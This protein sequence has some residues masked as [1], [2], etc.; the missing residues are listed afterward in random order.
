[1]LRHV[2]RFPSRE[3]TRSE[4]MLVHTGE[5]IRNYFAQPT[6]FQSKNPIR[7]PSPPPSS[8]ESITNTII[9]ESMDT[10][11]TPIA[12]SLD[13]SSRVTSEPD[14]MSPEETFKKVSFAD[15]PEKMEFEQDFPALEN[16][17]IFHDKCLTSPRQR[18]ASG[19]DMDLMMALSNKKE[20]QI[21]HKPS[22][23]PETLT[24]LM[25]CGNLAIG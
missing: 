18:R 13:S 24:H 2:C 22:I 5:H 12:E 14:E 1:V 23:W 10:T 11:N 3:I 19:L 21:S 7:F 15:S 8:T 9:T 20:E 6:W 16:E 4:L 25:G 17:E